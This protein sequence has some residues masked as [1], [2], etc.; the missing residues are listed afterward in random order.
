M[1]P[2]RNCVGLAS[3]A[4]V[5]YGVTIRVTCSMWVFVTE[6]PWLVPVAMTGM[7]YV[8]GGVEPG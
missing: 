8:P 2:T 6:L 3:L 7:T 1:R 5:G 4:R